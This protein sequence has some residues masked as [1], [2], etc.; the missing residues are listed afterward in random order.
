M[1]YLSQII[2]GQNHVA[3]LNQLVPQAEAPAV[4]YLG[5]KA[6]PLQGTQDTI[7]DASVQTEGLSEFAA[8]PFGMLLVK[9]KQYP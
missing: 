4:A 6:S 7:Y 8:A 3:Q 2:A 1:G 9:L 5:Y